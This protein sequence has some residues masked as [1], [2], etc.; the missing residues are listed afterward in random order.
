[1]PANVAFRPYSPAD[2]QYCLDIFEG[3][4][5]EFF[6]PNE[7]AEYEKFLDSNSANY[8]VCCI[9]PIVVGAFGLIGND[10]RTRNLNWILLNTKLQGSGIGSAIMER[11]MSLARTLDLNCV[12]IAASHKSA[13]FFSRFGA[14]CVESVND[15]WGPGMHRINME[16]HLG[17]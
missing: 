3:N 11:I 2:K 7:R 6:A 17:Q 14:I 16:L 9:G 1:M 4:C 8:E 13:A 10:A 12:S 5:P 15:G